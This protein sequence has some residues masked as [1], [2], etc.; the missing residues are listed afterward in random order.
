MGYPKAAVLHR[1]SVNLS[2]AEN[3]FTNAVSFF[4]EDGKVLYTQPMQENRD[5][6]PKRTELIGNAYYKGDTLIPGPMDF[7]VKNRLSLPDLSRMLKTILFP[8]SM[9][10][11][12]RFNLKPEEYGFI[13]KC[14]SQFPAESVSP[15]YNQ[16]DYPDAF[17]KF[18][19]YGGEKGSKPKHNR[20][21]NKREDAY[22]FLTD[23]AYIADF[24]NNIE[25]M[26]GATIYCNKDGILNDDRYDYDSIGLPFLNNLGKLIYD[27]ELSRKRK[28]KPD[29]SGFKLM[30]DS[31][32][33]PG[34][35]INA[36][37]GDQPPKP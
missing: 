14:M 21:F 6:Y 9:P 7:S 32:P 28:V 33:S 12:Q 13:L 8:A 24:E 27:H 16:A 5:I 37:N 29:L 23:V 36:D 35:G 25:F 31:V 11:Q 3:R 34:F 30:Y 22:G 10:V 20:I 17:C 1:L 2:E 26:L 15:E 18:L 19:F 4:N